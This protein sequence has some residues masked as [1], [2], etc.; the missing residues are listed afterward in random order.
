MSNCIVCICLHVS[1]HH[2][3]NLL[4]ESHTFLISVFLAAGTVPRAG[5][6][7]AVLSGE[8]LSPQL[9]HRTSWALW[10]IKGG[11]L[12]KPEWW[13]WGTICMNR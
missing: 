2:L 6:G 8:K 10:L 12:D 7:E 9:G 5:L 1:L 3:T 13:E 4:T 11:P